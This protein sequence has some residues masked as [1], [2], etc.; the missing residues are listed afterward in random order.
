MAKQ[1]FFQTCN[2][3]FRQ[4]FNVKKLV[5]LSF[6]SFLAQL[7]FAQNTIF[8]ID[9]LDIFVLPG[10][11]TRIAT[12][13]NE[14]QSAFENADSKIVVSLS[15]RLKSNFEFYNDTLSD[16][17][18]INTYYKWDSE[19]WKKDTKYDVSEIKENENGKYIIWHLKTPQG[20]NYMLYGIKD[21]HLIGIQIPDKK[22]RKKEDIIFLESLYLDKKQ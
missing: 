5:L 7:L 1:L 2:Y 8:K 9:S 13:V 6:F 16:Y 20:G 15:A 18:L 17:Q 22:L 14:G 4:S 21:N 19:Y 12:N 11:W 3:F 10:K